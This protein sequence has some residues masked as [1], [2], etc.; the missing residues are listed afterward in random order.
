MTAIAFS[1]EF[2]VGGS[3]DPGLR[4]LRAAFER[5]G[6]EVAN[7]GK[8]VFPRVS[9]ALEAA[10]SK[11]FEGEGVGSTG[12]W[13]V[14]SPRYAEWKEKHFPGALI[15][16]RTRALM[17]GLTDSSSSTARRESSNEALVFGTSGVEY[18]TFHQTGTK[19]MPAR[20]PLDMGEDFEAD[21]MAAAMAGV[22]EAVRAGSNGL[23]D[24]EGDTFTDETGVAR[25]VLTG[26][27]GGR[28][29]VNSSGTRT[30][31]KRSSSGQTVTRSFGRRA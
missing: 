8:Y 13:A 7:L 27:R 9:D 1:M 19:K 18:A 11:Q 17:S 22:R 24:F 23:L 10:T 31:L 6:A 28:F 29:Y 12:S 4:R 15:L 21:L 25:E 2:Y 26:S 14:L 30:Y 16:D 20:P 3:V 5:G